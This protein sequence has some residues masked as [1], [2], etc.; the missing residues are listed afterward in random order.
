MPT[1]QLKLSPAQP[2]E[3]VAA[4][5]R[6]VTQLSSD[7]LGKRHALTAVTVDELWPGRWFIAGAP[8]REPTAMLEIR[9]TAGTNTAQEKADFIAAA[10]ALLEQQLGSLAEASYVVVQEVAA[11]DWGYGGLTQAARRKTAVAV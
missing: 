8:A 10:Y 3:R 5:A 4:I 11:T 6:G 2:A 9:I 1:L 7:V